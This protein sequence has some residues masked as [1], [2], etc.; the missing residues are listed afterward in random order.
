[1]RYKY[2]MEQKKLRVELHKQVRN[3]KQ[4]DREENS[5]I[6]N[7][8]VEGEFDVIHENMK[9]ERIRDIFEKVYENQYGLQKDI[10]DSYV[11]Q[12]MM[13]AQND[14]SVDNGHIEQMR[15][16]LHEV[17]RKAIRS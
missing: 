6:Q 8:N 4:K 10:I 7:R 14:E 2:N 17:M 13:I 3:I 9:D 16:N 12:Y 1:M 11:D 15:C 5:Y